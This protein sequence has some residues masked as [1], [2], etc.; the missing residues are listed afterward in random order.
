M[1]ISTIYKIYTF[2]K[3]VIAMFKNIKL[4]LLGL[5]VLFLAGVIVTVNLQAKKIKRIEADNFRL[6]SN[7]VELISNA[8][9]QTNL[10]LKQNEVT[11][12]LERERDSFA[13]S[14]KIKPKT[15]DK[16]VYITNTI[17]DTIRVNVET[18]ITGPDMWKI[19]DQGACFKW[20]ANAFKQGDSLKVQ[21][22]SFEYNNKITEVFFRKKLKKFLFFKVGRW[23]NFYQ[24]EAECGESTVK[25]FQ[26]IK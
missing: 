5:A 21:R 18:I 16:L 26:F 24:V 13:K 6:E 9:K 14:L 8:D 3:P 25:T 23:H 11:G 4:Y 20:A 17:R 12:R 1:K 10:I 2:V 15:I 19:T 7:Q 22:T